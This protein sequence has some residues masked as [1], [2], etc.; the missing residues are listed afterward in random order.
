MKD[1]PD[2]PDELLPARRTYVPPP[3]SLG[4]AYD[5]YADQGPPPGK[6]VSVR[7]VWRALRRHW[8][9][10]LILW[11]A[12]SGALIALAYQRIKPT[13]DA[14]S[15]VLVDLGDDQIFAASSAAQVDHFQYMQTQVALITNPTTVGNALGKRPELLQFPMLRGVADPETEIRQALKVAILPKSSLIQVEMSSQNPAEAATIVNAVVDAYV[16][17]ATSKSDSSTKMRIERLTAIRE[18]QDRKVKN[19]RRVIGELAKS[20]VASDIKAAQ[21]RNVTSLDIYRRWNEELTR[22]QIMRITAKTRL[23]QLSKEKVLPPQSVDG[24]QMKAAV[25]DAFYAL[26]TVAALQGRIEQAESRL[27]DA[28][29]LNRNRSDPSVH[30]FAL[31]LKDLKEKKD[32]LWRRYEPRLTRGLSAGPVDDSIDRVIKEAESNLAALMTQENELGARLD[33]LKIENK[34]AESDA[35]SLEF[36]RRD[37]EGEESVLAQV[38][39]TL[40]QLE[41]EAKSPKAQIEK[42]FDAKAPNRPNSDRRKQVM[43]FAPVATAMLVTA[44]L[45]LLELRGARVSDPDELAS[46]IRLQVIGVVPPL[47]Q[48]RPGGYGEGAGL[49]AT[50][51]DIRAQRE[52]DV[53][54]QSL[55]HL[56][57][58]L[59]AHKDPW[60]RDRHCVLITSACGSEGKTTLAAQLAERCVN[61]GMMTLLIDGD[62]RNPTLSR[63]LDATESPGLINVLRGEAA[64]EDAI[65]VVGDAGGFHLLPAGNP[66]VDPSRLL[67]NDRLGRL[68]AQARESFDMVI[69]DAPPVLPVPDAL[70]IGKWVDGA[71][72]AVRYDTS[73]FPLVERANRRLAHVGVPVIG[74]VVNGVRSVESSYGG[75]Y[76]YGAY[77]SYG[78]AAPSST[79]SA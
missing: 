79:P 68:I 7:L 12:G 48:I 42:V 62:L 44:L 3:A 70:T 71:V 23:D 38:Q 29:R 55:D 39:K 73:R 45:V 60:G 52:L 20:L 40:N 5:D 34:A 30:K 31:Q 32:E 64:A 47:P 72:L 49:P 76:A 21:S 14:I 8:W 58:A 75:Y 15:Q 50:Q 63:M 24:E 61:A 33:K 53:F 1:T 78:S 16:E 2:R 54:V 67:Q 17:Q 41:F 56:R 11:L 22:V 6:K 59:C 77:G 28:E 26:P 69:I 57:V 35:L 65:S 10:A 46:R 51:A 74:A 25:G 43:A 13:Y 36:N 66:R 19:H 9:Q 37:L 18:E 27:K 4:E